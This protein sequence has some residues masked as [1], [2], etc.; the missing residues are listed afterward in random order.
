MRATSAPFWNIVESVDEMLAARGI[1]DYQLLINNG[2]LAA[3]FR[4]ALQIKLMFDEDKEA[5]FADPK[6]CR[7]SAGGPE[8]EDFGVHLEEGASSAAV[9]PPA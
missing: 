1:R 7:D 4:I 9:P 6:A 3:Q 8:R 2:K 5:L